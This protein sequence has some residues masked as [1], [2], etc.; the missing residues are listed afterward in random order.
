[1][2]FSIT[3]DDLHFVGFDELLHFPELH[4]LE[5]KGPDVVT[6]SVRAQV[7]SLE[8]KP[9]LHPVSQGIVDGLIEL[10]QYLQ[11]QVRRD[12]TTLEKGNVCKRTEKQTT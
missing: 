3:G 9:R 1:M 7:A 12:L 2:V 4:I 11:G 6:E 10:Q 5:D 8:S